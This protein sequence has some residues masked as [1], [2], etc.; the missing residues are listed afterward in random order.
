ML[1]FM[2]ADLL[3]ERIGMI[4]I[5]IDASS[6]AAR[7]VVATSTTRAAGRQLVHGCWSAPFG[8]DSKTPDR[9]LII[10]HA[11]EAAGQAGDWAWAAR[12]RQ[13]AQRRPR[14]APG[15]LDGRPRTRP[16]VDSRARSAGAAC[17][18]PA[19]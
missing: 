3:G 16:V 2:P 1:W 14:P 13:F 12:S 17:C 8:W 9:W 5:S 15:R 7:S 4:F 18:R 19:R 10:G 11:Y 6:G